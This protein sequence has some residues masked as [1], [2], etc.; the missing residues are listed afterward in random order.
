VQINHPR[1]DKSDLSNFQASFD[2]AGLRFDFASRAFFGDQ[3]LM[4]IT[5]ELL[6]LPPDAQMFGTNFDTVEVMNGFHVSTVDG[7][8]L[9]TRAETILRDWMN[10]LS[11]GF[12]P[13]PT[14]VSDTHTWIADPAGMPRTLVAVADDSPA[15]VAA[16]IGPQI[17]DVLTGA[18][19][20]ARDVVITNG[21]FLVFTV[22]GMGIARTV[23]HTSGPLAIHLEA[24]AP[25]WMP[26]DMVEVFANSTFDVP[27]DSPAAL[28]PL[29]CFTS[30]PSP[31]A[32]CMGALG[33]ARPLP[34]TIVQT[35]AGVAASSRQD[36][37]IDVSDVTVDQIV[38]RNRAG[39][40]GRDAWL[41]ARVSGTQAMYPSLPNEVQ[42]AQVSDLI[43]GAAVLD[44]GVPPLA[45]TNAI[46]VDADGGGWRAPFAP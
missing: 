6:A 33:G 22:D 8:R 27:S 45:I 26:L 18:N 13:T 16:G 30:R 1:A 20:H 42:K 44:E 24:H 34:S 35:V 46:F 3:S 28:V 36:I 7:E 31:S 21:P 41:V 29:L 15:A 14:G 17:A 39:A 9:D 43:A 23:S 19:G 4:P 11:F 10:F 32:R 12:A 25:A 2:R 40:V 5:L 38:A 37:V